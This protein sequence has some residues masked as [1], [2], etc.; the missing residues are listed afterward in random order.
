MADH[1]GR[2]HR[3][4][5]RTARAGGKAV[6]HDHSKSASCAPT[7]AAARQIATTGRCAAGNLAPK[8]TQTRR[9][10]TASAV[11]LIAR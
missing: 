9:N 5:L 2:D 3:G 4:K 11:Y 10:R 6:A 7:I 1:L 8:T